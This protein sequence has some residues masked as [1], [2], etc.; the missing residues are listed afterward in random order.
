MKERGNKVYKF[1]DS[2]IGSIIIFALQFMH[3]K[4][5]LPSLDSIKKITVIQ[6]GAI[7]DTILLSAILQDIKDTLP[8]A[9]ITFICSKGNK[10]IVEHLQ[11]IDDFY[12]F[13][14]KNPLASINHI[15][16][17]QQCDLVLDFTPW[18][19]IGAIISFFIHARYKVGFKQK[20]MTRH[21]LYDNWIE[22][23]NEVH[24][25][26]NY[27]NIVHLLG[28]AKNNLPSLS[29]QENLD[30]EVQEKSVV[31]HLFAGG[32]KSY[33]RQWTEENW[34]MLAKTLIKNGF[35]IYLT[36]A[37][38]DIPSAELFCE[39]ADF[40]NSAS[41]VNVTGKLSLSQTA[42]LLTK[43]CSLITVNTGI[44]HLADSLNV[45]TISLNGPTNIKRWGGIHDS[46]TNLSTQNV[47]C[48][49]CL[50]LGFE[51]ACNDEHPLCM[52]SISV[53]TVLEILR[54]KNLIEVQ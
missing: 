45:P 21:L 28:I 44:L 14:F 39:R 34:I 1:I 51:Y 10:G 6:L 26:I 49:P 46:T 31:F 40:A 47:P 13:N 17:I 27:K 42:T 3:K 23:S 29:M 9:K 15:R 41:I 4:N 20:N 19:K 36:G 38:Q 8:E 37:K 24:E 33:M 16:K 32:T 35:T 25:V 52:K 18:A 12:S 22:H 7:G 54:K 30:F 2:V 53:E 48:S 11:T 43:V 5:K 50:N